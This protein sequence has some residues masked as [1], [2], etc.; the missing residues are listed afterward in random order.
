METLLNER[1]LCVKETNAV[2]LDGM[3]HHRMVISS[4]MYQGIVVYAPDHE[5][6]G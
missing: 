4:K 1:D 5:E 3:A 2:S 6:L